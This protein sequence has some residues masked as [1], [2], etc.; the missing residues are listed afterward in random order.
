MKMVKFICMLQNI[1]MWNLYRLD[2]WKL[3]NS[4][5]LVISEAMK[6]AINLTYYRRKLQQKYNKKN[7]IIPKTIFSSI[8]DMWI[9]SSKTKRDYSNLN[10]EE[11]AKTLSRLELEMDIAS[12]NM[13]YEKAAEL[14]DQILY[15][16][17]GK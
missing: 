16:K 9:T 10:K 12:W 6:K 17:K 3:V 4:D 15:L 7:N 2:K 1:Y 8:K 11:I 13:E 14:R 5:G